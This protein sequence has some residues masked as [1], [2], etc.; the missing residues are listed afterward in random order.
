LLNHETIERHRTVQAEVY[1]LLKE[2]TKMKSLISLMTGVAAL[3]FTSVALGQAPPPPPPEP[4]GGVDEVNAMILIDVSGSM[5]EMHTTTQTKLETALQRAKDKI[6]E[7]DAADAGKP[8]EYALWAFDS[9][10]G[11]ANGWVERVW[12]FPATKTQVLESL[13]FSSTGAPLPAGP[14]P[15]FTP[16]SSTPLAGSGCYLGAYLVASVDANG[17]LISGGYEW[18]KEEAL[19]DR[20]EIKRRLYIGTDGLEN[21]TPT[22][23]TGS[24]CG[25]TTSNQTYENFEPGSWQAKLRN[26]LLT[27]NATINTTLDSLLTVDVDLIFQNYISGLSGGSSEQ[28]YSTGTPYTTEPTLNQALEFYGGLAANTLGGKFK[29]VTVDASGAI[30]SR[31]PGDVDYSGCVGNADYTELLQWYGQAVSPSHPHSYWADLNGDGWV[32]YLDYLILYNHWGD[33]GIC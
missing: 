11:A 15:V 5:A 1:S 22:S 16:T 4:P 19:G 8:K 32:D 9:S 3:A 27:G 7:W 21:A 2:K 23:G 26:K 12:D 25:G 13:G 6:L 14:D 30:T 17:A 10:F 20:A 29:T 33:G 28:N 24:E 31:R 18:N